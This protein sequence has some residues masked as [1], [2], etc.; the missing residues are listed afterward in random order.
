MGYYSKASY[1]V[2]N[3]NQIHDLKFAHP[4]ADGYLFD[5]IWGIPG[6][7]KIADGGRIRSLSYTLVKDYMVDWPWKWQKT[8][9]GILSNE[10]KFENFKGTY[11]AI[12]MVLGKHTR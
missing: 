8:G 2:Y 12:Q 7:Y 5:Y 10:Y 4:Y 6:H 3:Y 11:N 9:P 1:R